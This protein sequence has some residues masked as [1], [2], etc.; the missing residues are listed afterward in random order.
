MSTSILTPAR[1]AHYDRNAT[2]AVQGV[3]LLNIAPHA[4]TQR[5]IITCSAGKKILLELATYALYRQTAATTATAWGTYHLVTSGAT[6]L[7]V[8]E[9]QTTSNTVAFVNSVTLGLQ[10]TIYAGET[11]E[12]YT[13]DTCGGG[14][15]RYILGAKGTSFDA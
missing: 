9:Y 12:G 7:H 15:C 5:T 8:L 3:D 2:T 13:Y 6:Q 11:F 14:T 4:A 1:A 10:T